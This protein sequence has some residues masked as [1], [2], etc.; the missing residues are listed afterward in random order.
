MINL[1]HVFVF[2]ITKLKQV[3]IL[4]RFF[5]FIVPF[6]YASLHNKK[7]KEK[8][9]RGETNH[10][11]IKDIKSKDLFSFFSIQFIFLIPAFLWYAWVMPGWVGNPVLKGIFENS[12]SF[13]GII[14]ILRYHIDTMFPK[15]LLNPS[16]WLFFLIGIISFR[17]F[18]GGKEFG[19]YILAMVFITFLYFIL[20]F[21]AI[22]IVHDYYMMPFLP[23][24]YIISAVGFE[25]MIRLKYSIGKIGAISL[26]FI[27]PY[28]AFY[29]NK[30]NWSIEKTYFN[31]DVFIY[32]EELK[33]AVPQDEQCI[34]LNDNSYYVFSYQID[35]M[36]HIFSNDHLPI[37]WIDDMINRL[38]IKYMYSDSRKIDT[39]AAFQPYIDSLLIQAGS[40]KVFKLKPKKKY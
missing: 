35:K 31:P 3:V 30:D 6:R 21:N 2:S 34:I 8:V 9:Q 1:F 15:I 4:S 28:L 13:D 25:Y 5:L 11:V 14:K 27:S 12:I 7:E 40:I 17:K 36:G 16:S 32:K 22:G 37:G 26:L 18:K 19:I 38:K 24:L 33:N 39:S 20:E 23:W 10:I 29:L